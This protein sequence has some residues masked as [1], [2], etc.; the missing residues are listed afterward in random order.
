MP[1]GW[2]EDS[3]DR[4]VVEPYFAFEEE[5][6]NVRVSNPEIFL[7]YIPSEQ[8]DTFFPSLAMEHRW[9]GMAARGYWTANR[10]MYVCHDCGAIGYKYGTRELFKCYIPHCR[11][12]NITICRAGELSIAIRN[13]G[14]GA[15]MQDVYDARQ[16]RLRRARDTR[17]NTRSSN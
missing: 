15:R 11:S 16:E 2:D 5:R 6:R 14:I 17:R 4:I 7:P 12:R 13:L 10:M 8:L 3:N 9:E 1:K